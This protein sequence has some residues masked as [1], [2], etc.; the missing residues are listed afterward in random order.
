MKLRKIF[1]RAVF[2]LILAA[3]AALPAP[4]DVIQTGPNL[5][6]AGVQT[7]QFSTAAQNSQ[8]WCW[9][10]CIEMVL[11][12][13]GVTV[14]QESVVERIYGQKVDHAAD[15]RQILLALSGWG[16]NVSGGA[17]RIYAEGY[18]GI[19]PYF[20]QDLINGHPLIAGLNYGTNIGHAVVLT[21]VSFSADQFGRQTPYS[22]VIRDPWPT[23]PD[24]QEMPIAAFLSGCFF[25]ARV[26]AYP[27]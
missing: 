3:V 11:K 22:V 21:A 7:I 19:Y 25:S 12:Y 15:P 1:P 10:A 13:H 26:A 20:I 9:A 5:Y 17:S 6:V 14:S 27:Y 16:P 18:Q 24:R 2:A 8:N 4:G 23:N